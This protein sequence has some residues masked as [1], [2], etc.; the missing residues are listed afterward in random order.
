MRIL[1]KVIIFAAVVLLFAAIFQF[2]DKKSLFESYNYTFNI[3][4]K[5]E[6]DVSIEVSNFYTVSCD[7]QNA[8]K[9]LRNY[10]NVLGVSYKFESSEFEIDSFISENNFKI[11]FTQSIN[12]RMIYYLYNYKISNY[13]IVN[14]KKV[15]MQIV[16]ADDYIVAGLPLILGA[17]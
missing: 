13:E 1:N 12:D 9:V 2:K 6:A 14:D 3:Y 15:S 10:N 8:D 11:Q 16:K 4:V 17:Y 5:S 7:K